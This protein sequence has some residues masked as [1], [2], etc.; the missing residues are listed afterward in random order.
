LKAEALPTGHEQ[1]EGVA[2][3]PD[4]ILI[5][6]DEATRTPAAITLYRWRR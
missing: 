2:V 1:A 5:I 6:S 3:T 4:G